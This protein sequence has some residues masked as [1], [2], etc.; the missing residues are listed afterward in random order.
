M[1]RFFRN[2]E[3][4]RA[5]LTIFNKVLECYRKI[6]KVDSKRGGRRNNRIE[7]LIF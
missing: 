6:S 1:T 5:N 2:S 7:E 3:I 4:D